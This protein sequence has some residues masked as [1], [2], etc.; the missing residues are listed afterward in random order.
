LTGALGAAGLAL[1]PRIPNLTSEPLEVLHYKA[2]QPW[3]VVASAILLAGSLYVL[4][5]IRQKRSGSPIWITIVL[6]A[7]A[8]IAGQLVLQ[9]TEPQ[10]RYRAGLALVAPIEAE[11]SPNTKLYM[12][13]LYDQTLPFYLRRTMTLVEHADELAFGLQQEPELWLPTMQAFLQQWATK[14]KAIAI[15]RHEIFAELEKQGIPMRVIAQDSRRIVITNDLENKP[16]G[17]TR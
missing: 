15:T 9:G 13:G 7:S 6:A 14:A 2:S 8:F 1:A 5:C 12:V 16:M 11:L 4:L 17:S 3:I 10:G